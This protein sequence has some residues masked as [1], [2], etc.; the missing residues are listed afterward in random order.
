MSG[1]IQ[2]LGTFS[3]LD[4]HLTWPVYSV[5]IILNKSKKKTN[6]EDYLNKVSSVSETK[7]R[8]V[9]LLISE[10]AKHE[11]SKFTYPVHLILTLIELFLFV[12]KHFPEF[13]NSWDARKI[14]LENSEYSLMTIKWLKNSFLSLGC[15]EFAPRLDPQFHNLPRTDSR[16]QL[17]QLQ[18]RSVT[19]M[20]S[21]DDCLS[22][23]RTLVFSVKQLVVFH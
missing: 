20:P 2:F 12:S 15:N 21:V 6:L 9:H 3:F 17:V 19:W 8:E 16:I 7:K 22:L 23:P 13:N 4:I 1:R 14:F 10:E 18:E 11:D 5:I